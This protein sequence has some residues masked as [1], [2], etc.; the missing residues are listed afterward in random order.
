MPKKRIFTP[1]EIELIK[2]LNDKY[3]SYNYIAGQLKCNY[4]TLRNFMEEAGIKKTQARLVDHELRDDFF[5]CIDTEEK[6]YLLGLLKTDGYIKTRRDTPTIGIQL[7]KEDL[8]I[9]E[10]IK[11]LWNSATK[12]QHDKRP[13]KECF[14]IEVRSKQMAEDLAKYEIVPRKTYALTNIH[15]E[16]IPKDLQRHYLRGLV[17]GDGTVSTEGTQVYVSFCGYSEDFVRSFQYAID[18]LLGK[19]THNQIRKNNAYVCRWKGNNLSR[20]ILNYLYKDSTIFIKRK[21]QVYTD[22]FENE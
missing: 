19:E 17:D 4:M 2:N 18:E 22:F 7:K 14:G 8:Y 21:K 10:Q 1:E 20:I 9:I 6:A 3:Y 16:Q 11:E 5:S 12:I 13:N 15:L